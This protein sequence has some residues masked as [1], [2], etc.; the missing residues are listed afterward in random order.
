MNLNDLQTFVAIAEL[1]SFSAAAERLN[2]TQ[3]AVSKRMANLEQAVGAQLIDRVGRT[4]SL[5]AAGRAML[6]QAQDISSRTRDAL[7]EVQALNN[8]V[9][10]ELRLA[11]SHHIGLH[12][13]A[14]VLEQFVQAYPDVQLNISFEDSEVAHQMVNHGSVELAVV[15]LDPNGESSLESQLIW[16]DPLCFVNRLTDESLQDPLELSALV[17][18]PCV[19]PGSATYTGRIIMQAFE[20]AGLTLKPTMSTN[21]LETISMLVSVG[22]GWSVLP[23]NMADRLQHL[24]VK[25]PTL[26][27]HLGVITNPNRVLSNPA[28]AFL[29]TLTSDLPHI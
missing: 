24:S 14:P 10:G 4:I 7:R 18:M 23:I 19:L 8:A 27:R 11:T 28:K 29:E 26:M 17:E 1:G 12:R 21:Y 9:K 22:L 13:L 15:T 3:P 2:I 6:P 20:N 25:H 16:E 5:T